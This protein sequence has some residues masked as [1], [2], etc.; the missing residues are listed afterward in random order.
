MTS[1]Y[2]PLGMA[3]V[4]VALVIH[5]R[6][7]VSMPRAARQQALRGA[8]GIRILVLTALSVG[9]AG[10]LMIENGKKALFNEPLVAV[11]SGTGSQKLRRFEAEIDLKRAKAPL[12]LTL[13]LDPGLSGSISRQVPAHILLLTPNG[14]PVFEE[15][16]LFKATKRA[17]NKAAERWQYEPDFTT[18]F[19]TESSDDSDTS[20]TSGSYRLRVMLPASSGATPRV[21]IDY[22][23]DTGAEQN[24]D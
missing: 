16:H 1:L 7:L 17:T 10:W 21:R 2:L 19:A 3:L 6:R 12:Q 18:R 13:Y 14:Q 9:L 8:F 24:R 4:V 22:A 20:G 15:T 23:K 11:S 5:I